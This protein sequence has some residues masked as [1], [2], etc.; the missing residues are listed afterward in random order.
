MA[1]CIVPTQSE[2]V[3][4]DGQ[5][6]ANKP[7]PMILRNSNPFSLSLPG[8]CR[9]H[10][11]LHRL[12]VLLE[13]EAPDSV[14]LLYSV[15]AAVSHWPMTSGMA[16]SSG[17]NVGYRVVSIPGRGRP[18]SAASPLFLFKVLTAGLDPN[19]EELLPKIN[20]STL[21]TR[22]YYNPPANR[23]PCSLPKLS[24]LAGRSSFVD[25]RELHKHPIL[26]VVMMIVVANPNTV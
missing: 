16:C 17:L 11:G 3:Q 5:P 6:R 7:L 18:G 20:T 19:R 26:L 9:P 24:C 10:R 13:L 4:A 25:S 23:S 15:T 2:A 22:Q 1:M 8:S 21:I 14:M 12:R